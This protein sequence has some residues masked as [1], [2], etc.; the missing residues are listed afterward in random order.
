MSPGVSDPPAEPATQQLPLT[1]HDQAAERT[2]RRRRKAPWVIALV[3][4]TLS[5]VLAAV[6]WRSRRL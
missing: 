6:L 2:G 5:V 3:V 4:S 1:P